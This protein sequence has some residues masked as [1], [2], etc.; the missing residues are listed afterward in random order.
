MTGHG[1]ASD[2]GD[3]AVGVAATVAAW[4]GF[5]RVGRDRAWVCRV[6]EGDEF[7]ASL[8]EARAEVRAEAAELL[9]S[10]A[11]PLVAARA[12]MESARALW[13]RDIPF[14]GF[15]RVAVQYTKARS[16]QFCARVIDPGL[17]EVQPLLSWDDRIR[18]VGGA[19]VTASAAPR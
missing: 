4:R 5:A 1:S 8:V 9:G 3:V 2:A 13:V 18:E 16:W 6:C 14:V 12:M 19:R 11:D 17:E 15:D 10:A 7:A